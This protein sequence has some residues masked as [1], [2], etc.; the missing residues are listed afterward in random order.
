MSKIDY[1]P[2]GPMSYGYVQYD[3]VEGYERNDAIDFLI[4]EFECLK[5]N[6]ISKSE[7]QKF[8]IVSASHHGVKCTDQDVENAY[9]IAYGHG[10]EYE[11]Y[12]A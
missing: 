2:T 5:K 8:W 11:W 10:C 1:S 4:S 3:I 12:S 7:A 6:I 9:N